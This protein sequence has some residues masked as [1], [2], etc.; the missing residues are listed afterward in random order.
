[1]PLKFNA[2]HQAVMLDA[3]TPVQ[4]GEQADV[5]DDIA[6]LWVDEDPRAGLDAEREFKRLRD[7]SRAELDEELAGLGLDPAQFANKQA[8]IEAIQAAKAAPVAAGN[9][10]DPAEPDGP[11]DNEEQSQ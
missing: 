4:P 3:F 11:A 5:P 8:A 2:D 10:T 7:A 1:M 9:I 6:G